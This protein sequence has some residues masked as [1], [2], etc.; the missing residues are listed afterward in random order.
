M[1]R[2]VYERYNHF[3][4]LNDTI[5]LPADMCGRT[6]FISHAERNWRLLVNF[7]EAYAI[8]RRERPTLLLSTGAG[9]AVPFAIVGRLMSIPS[10][11]IETATRVASPS[12]S[13]RVM[14]HLATKFFYQ[15][16]SLERYFPAGTYGGPML[17]S[18]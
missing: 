8:L 10:I 9:P 12:L 6:Y 2:P 16:R 3:Y 5:D 17:W 13:G 4:V 7:I 14:Y 11:Y 15:W 18:S 1:L